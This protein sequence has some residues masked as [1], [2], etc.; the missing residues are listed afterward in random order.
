M[1]RILTYA[2]VAVGLVV[3][4]LLRSVGNGIGS[5]LRKRRAHLTQARRHFIKAA[6][7]LN[8]ARNEETSASQARSLAGNAITEADL[9]IELNPHDAASLIVKSL[10]L[11]LLKKPV[12]A[13]KVLN[14]AL[15]KEFSK[16]LSKEERADTLVQKVELTLEQMNESNEGMQDVLKDLQESISLNPANPRTHFMLGSCC[17]R[18]GDGE[19]ALVAYQ[20]AL[21]VS[22]KFSEAKA[23]LERLNS[24][25][26]AP[27]V[28]ASV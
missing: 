26:Q 20:Q 15:S 2:L 22:P 17:E 18:L 12:A 14:T 8:K 1:E 3:V 5:R 24:P 28:A 10:A 6:M 27:S 19:D 16:T 25:S 9:A 11:R 23:A 4:L 21:A 13:L 7:L